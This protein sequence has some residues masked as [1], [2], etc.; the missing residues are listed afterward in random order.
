MKTETVI[1]MDNKSRRQ[2]EILEIHYVQKYW[3]DSAF[4]V[5]RRSEM[6][7]APRVL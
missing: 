6:W 5:K 2:K 7:L 4:L 1:E 3:M